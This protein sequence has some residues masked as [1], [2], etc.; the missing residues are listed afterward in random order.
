MKYLKR[1]LADV[2]TGQARKAL[3]AAAAVLVTI[4]AVQGLPSNYVADIK[5]IL[6]VLA[7]F[8]VTYQVSNRVTV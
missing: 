4:G 6:S 1:L 5:D 7:S 8:G 3:V 2:R